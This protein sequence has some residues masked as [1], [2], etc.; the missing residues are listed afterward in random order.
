MSDPIAGTALV[1][2]LLAGVNSLMN[3][4]HIRKCKAF[5]CQ[6]ECSKGTTPPQSP[7]PS[8]AI[9]DSKKKKQASIKDEN[10]NSVNV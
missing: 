3:T 10:D 1:I 5:G 6:S 7:K 2:A 4:L 8:L 9:E